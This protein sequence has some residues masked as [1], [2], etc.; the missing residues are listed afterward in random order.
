MHIYSYISIP[1][2]M[3]LRQEGHK[4]NAS[5]GSIATLKISV[6]VSFCLYLSLCLCLCLSLSVYVCVC[7]RVSVCVYE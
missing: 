5:L 1:G 6:S 4:F 3:L 7:V 2:L